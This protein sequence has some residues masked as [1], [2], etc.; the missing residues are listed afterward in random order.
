MENEDYKILWT[1]SI[2]IDHVIEARRLDLVEVDKKRR[3]CKM[4][5]SEI[6]GV[7][8]IKEKEKEKLKKYQNLSKELQKNWKRRAK[9]IP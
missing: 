9:I 6:S 2:Q 1:F 3:T 4:I 8:K 7:S 5:D